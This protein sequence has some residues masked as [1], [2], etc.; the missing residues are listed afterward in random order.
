MLRRKFLFSLTVVLVAAIIFGSVVKSYAR[1]EIR[2]FSSDTD[3]AETLYRSEIRNVLKDAGVKN[4]GITMTKKCEDGRTFEYDVMINLPEYID[5]N[6]EAKEKL[7]ES[8]QELELDVSDSSVE[9]TLCR[10]E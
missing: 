5:K 10:K 7:V 3:E 2:K 6:E 9:F 1:S 4:A 8:L